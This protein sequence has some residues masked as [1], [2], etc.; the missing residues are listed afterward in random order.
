MAIR[1]TEQPSLYENLEKKSIAE[2]LHDINEEDKKV[3]LAIERILPDLEKLISAIERQLRDGGRMFYCGCGTGG[4]LAVLDTLE[5]PNTYG[6]DP[7][8]IQCVLGGGVEN[9]VL[10]LEEAEDDVEEGWQTLQ[11]KNISPKD[12]V[13]GISASGNTPYV[14]ATL[15]ACREHG[16][17]TGSLVNNPNSPISKYSDYPIEVITGPEFITGSTRM[18][19]GTSQK[20]ICDMISTTVMVRLGRVEGNRMVNANLINNKVIDRL[21]RTMMERNPSLK[22][23]DFCEQT[24]KRCGGLKKA[25]AYLLKKGILKEQPLGIN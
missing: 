16:I 2:L 6:C 17:P 7:E 20:L 9:L 3:P 25:E 14:L 19:A 24:I 8:L 12:I 18:K 5:L 13:V 10:D 21:T 11:E 15:K 4:K 23:Y 22:D 1:L